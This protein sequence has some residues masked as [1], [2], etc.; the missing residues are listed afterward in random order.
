MFVM[1][2]NETSYNPDKDHVV[3][4]ASCTTNCLAPLAKV[5]EVFTCADLFVCVTLTFADRVCVCMC[6]FMCMCMYTCFLGDTKTF[7]E[8]QNLLRKICS[9]T[10]HHS[11]VNAAHVLRSCNC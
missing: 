3:S 11:S 7:T 2:V 9:S 6:M 5:R 10:A 1:G 8:A 4:N